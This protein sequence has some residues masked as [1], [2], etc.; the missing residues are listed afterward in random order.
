MVQVR[1]TL[2]TTAAKVLRSGG[3]H[4]IADLYAIANVG[5]EIVIS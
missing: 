2:R 4:H 1:Q 5:D 3:D